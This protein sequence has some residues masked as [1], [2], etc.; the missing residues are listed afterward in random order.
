MVGG[1]IRVMSELAVPVAEAA[2][3]FLRVLDLAESRGEPTTLLRDG[4]PVAKLVP[5]PQPAASCEQLAARWE[6]LYKL[7]ADEAEAFA[8]DL[9]SARASLPL[10]KPAWD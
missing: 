7:P 6:K 1:Y 4:K 5:L 8:N 2:K 10:L 3:D 9:E